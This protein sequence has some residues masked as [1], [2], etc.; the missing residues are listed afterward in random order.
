MTISSFYYKWKKKCFSIIYLKVF[1]YVYV[2]LNRVKAY[3]LWKKAEF[4]DHRVTTKFLYGWNELEKTI[5]MYHIWNSCLGYSKE[6]IMRLWEGSCVTN[7]GSYRNVGNTG[8]LQQ[9]LTRLGLI[10]EKA[11][12]RRLSKGVKAFFVKCFQIKIYY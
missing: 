1:N 8:P 6:K 10:K 7:G 4:S 2:W 9:G 5:H 3:F 12:E 11:W